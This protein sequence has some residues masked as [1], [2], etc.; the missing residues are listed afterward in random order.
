[1]RVC[2]ECTRRVVHEPGFDRAVPVL[3]DAQVVLKRVDVEVRAKANQSVRSGER[4]Y[5]RA[6]QHLDVH[7]VITE[8]SWCDPEGLV[9][10]QPCKEL[11]SPV[12]REDTVY[13]PG[14]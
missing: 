11:T 13:V 1:M 12:T 5:C 8:V 14:M 7:T 4:S 10:R 6:R 9:S 3:I 2:R